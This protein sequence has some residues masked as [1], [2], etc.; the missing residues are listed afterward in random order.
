MS[1]GFRHML[2]LIEEEINGDDYYK[3]NYESQK[4]MNLCNQVY[5]IVSS[6][7]TVILAQQ[8]EIKSKL[9]HVYDLVTNKDNNL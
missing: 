7:S 2:E 8:T 3:D 5:L 4:L 9:D 6:S 1:I